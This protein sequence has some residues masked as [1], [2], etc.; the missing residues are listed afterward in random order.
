[1]MSHRVCRFEW[2]RSGAPSMTASVG[3]VFVIFVWASAWHW[4]TLTNYPAFSAQNKPD[5]SAHVW[6]G[7]VNRIKK[8][9]KRWATALL[10]FPHI[11]GRTVC[12]Q[13]ANHVICGGCTASFECH[14]KRVKQVLGHYLWATY[15]Y[16]WN[17]SRRLAAANQKRDAQLYGSGRRKGRIGRGDSRGNERKKTERSPKVLE[18][19][20]LDCLVRN[21]IITHLDGESLSC[22]SFLRFCYRNKKSIRSKMYW[23]IMSTSGKMNWKRVDCCWITSFLHYL[24]NCSSSSK[25]WE[26]KMWKF[27][28]VHMER[29]VKCGDSKL[30]TIIVIV[31]QS[32]NL[33]ST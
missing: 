24:D 3:A 31:F 30:A 27:N 14:R 19:H 33:L 6:L 17:I 21:F 5:S 25:V 32:L 26:V 15:A 1:M 13:L 23:L 7:Y 4:R 28:R 2:F 16:Q 10:A 12:G 29:A 9:K 20:Q 11:L 18:I 8:W 22:S